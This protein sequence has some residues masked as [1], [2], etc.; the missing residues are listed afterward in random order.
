MND[1]NLISEMHN[2]SELIINASKQSYQLKKEEEKWAALR[3]VQ[4]LTVRDC[5]P[6]ATV[7]L[8]PNCAKNPVAGCA[9]TLKPHTLT[10]H[11]L[12][13]ISLLDDF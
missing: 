3:L 2:L 7:S 5:S 13:H 12:W 8:D 9:T 4:N 1:C 6:A 10:H 11:C